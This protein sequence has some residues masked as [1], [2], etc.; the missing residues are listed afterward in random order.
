M[1][2]KELLLGTVVIVG[3]FS[4]AHANDKE[5]VGGCS[6]GRFWWHLCNLPINTK[7]AANYHNDELKKD[8]YCLGA[9]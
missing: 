2:M 7:S 3:L 9:Y 1:N 8:D 6:N 5:V 4:S